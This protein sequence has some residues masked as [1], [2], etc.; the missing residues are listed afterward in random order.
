VSDNWQSGPHGAPYGGA[1]GDPYGSPA[2]GP[3]GP[4]GSP[5]GDPYAQQSGG[6]G[7]PHA[8][9]SGGYGVPPGG[10]G[11][12]PY[13]HPHRETPPSQTSAIVA[14]VV[15]ILLVVSCCGFL[16][17]IGLVFSALSLSEKVDHEKA[18]R[19]ARYA[20]ISNGVI[21][22]ILA[23]LACVIGFAIAVSES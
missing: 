5:Y 8:H 7:D 20:W 1:P 9:A 13:A 22:G 15:S 3:S 11:T 12:D 10:Y 6:Y 18:R 14:L 16:G 4:Y 2:G 19:Q 17:V 21:L 23:V